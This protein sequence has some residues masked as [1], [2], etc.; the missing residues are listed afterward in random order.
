MQDIKQQFQNELMQRRARM[1]EDNERCK[2]L[3]MGL[4]L[5]EAQEK[6]QAQAKPPADRPATTQ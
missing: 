1:W 6:A 2:E 4:A 5:I 3:L